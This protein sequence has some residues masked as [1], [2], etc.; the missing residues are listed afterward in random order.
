MF[1]KILLCVAL[2]AGFGSANAAL[3]SVDARANSTSGSGSGFNTGINLTI[4]DYFTASAALDDL[5]NAGPL[6]RWSNADGLVADLFATG[7]DDSGQAA[8]VQIGRNFGLHNQHGLSLPFGT[9]VGSLDGNFFAMGTNFA[10][11]AIA[12]GEL[13]LWYW[14]SNN[15][16]NTESI[17][18]TIRT[19]GSVPEPSVIVLFGLG[20]LGIGLARRRRT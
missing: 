8:G 11:N 13:L 14:D 16:D 9:L 5:W 19:D 18:V 20:L 7:S 10:G 3:I 1:R 12:S 6:P 2:L 17:H 4:G 15:G